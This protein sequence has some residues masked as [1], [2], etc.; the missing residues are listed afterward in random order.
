[1][2]CN[3]RGCANKAPIPAVTA[4]AKAPQKVTRTVAVGVS[5]PPF[6][7]PTA[8]RRAR[9]NKDAAATDS[10][11]ASRK[12]QDHRQQRQRRTDRER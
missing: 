12:G 11:S 1:M 3:S 5:A 8:P 9:K 4:V 6:L 2:I 10:G 7:A